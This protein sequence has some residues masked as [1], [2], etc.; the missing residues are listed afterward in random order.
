M[1]I[2]VQG[3]KRAGMTIIKNNKCWRGRGEAG[4]SAC[5][6][7]E[8]KMQLLREPVWQLRS[9]HLTQQLH[10]QLSSSR[11]IKTYVHPKTGTQMFT[12]ALF[13][14][15]Q[16][17]TPKCPS[18]DEWNKMRQF[19]T[20]ERVSAII[21][22]EVLIHAITWMSLEKVMLCEKIQSERPHIV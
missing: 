21:R 18:T 9:F 4:A 15:N 8:C 13:K 6:W 14:N 19:H 2:L 16:V 17:T 1:W 22:N 11:E 5:W 10:S 20:M 12:A 3:G 7:W